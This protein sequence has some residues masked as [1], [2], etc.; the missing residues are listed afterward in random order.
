MLMSAPLITTPR[1]S[2]LGQSSQHL[3]VMSFIS[4][5]ILYCTTSTAN[6]KFWGVNALWAS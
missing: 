1:A 3:H 2:D 5:I 4:I 6:D